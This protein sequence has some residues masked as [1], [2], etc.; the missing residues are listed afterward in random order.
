[1][2]DP[3]T[4]PTLAKLLEAA[5]PHVAFDGWSE[6]TFRAASEDAEIDPAMAR[7]LCPRGAV[8]L[9][10]AFHAA[11]D[12]AMLRALAATDLSTMRIREK[13]TFAV[14]A[15]IE[16]IDAAMSRINDEL[17]RVGGLGS[18]LEALGNQT[19]DEEV[20][21]TGQLSEREDTDIAEAVIRLRSA[22]TSYEATLAA[23]ARS[24][25]TSLLDFLR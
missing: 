23:S 7:A 3:Q 12:A 17:G 24:L 10:V 11:G 13:I 5:L 22:E 20:R 8:D 14:R 19:L 6:T 25:N 18:R 15:R 2:T 4:D 21:V 1:M 16:A 9:A